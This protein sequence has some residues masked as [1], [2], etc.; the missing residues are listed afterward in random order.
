MSQLT[1][2]EPDS[3]LPLKRWPGFFSKAIADQW[4]QASLDLPWQRNE[5]VMFGKTMPVPRREYFVGDRP[6]YHYLYS[7]S[8]SLA[9]KPWPAFLLEMKAQVESATGYSFP[10]AM[11]NLYRNGNDSNGYHADDEPELG[12]HPAIA[13]VS[14][15]ETRTFRLKRK[16]KGSQS[17]GI[18]LNHGDL[19]LMLPGCQQEWL[20]TI[21]KTNRACQ[22]RVNWTFRPY[23]ETQARPI[24]QC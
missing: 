16:Q 18:E 7:R 4:L 20:H 17:I 12:D 14:L 1:L 21:T 8:V 15:G 22:L 23:D 24:Q 3:H 9:A 6:E 10:T 13:S 11:G 19:V 5:I 2:L